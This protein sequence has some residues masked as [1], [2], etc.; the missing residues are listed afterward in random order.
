L[1]SRAHN[2]DPAHEAAGDQATTTATQAGLVRLRHAGNRLSGFD[3]RCGGAAA[4]SAFVVVAIMFAVNIEAR[5]QSAGGHFAFI[6]DL[7]TE[8]DNVFGGAGKSV[9]VAYGSRQELVSLIVHYGNDMVRTYID[10]SA[11]N[12]AIRP[13]DKRVFDLPLGMLKLK[14]SFLFDESGCGPR[15]HFGCWRGTGIFQ[16]Y[17]HSHTGKNIIL[18]NQNCVLWLFHEHISPLND[19]SVASLLFTDAT[20][21]NC[22]PSNNESRQSGSGRSSFVRMICNNNPESFEK[23]YIES[24]AAYMCGGIIS[25]SLLFFAWWFTGRC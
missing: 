13:Q 19:A 11:R 5:A 4:L 25:A 24:F 2:Y 7:K 1:T 10:I 22:E 20:Q 9:V 23:S 8:F 18:I 12:F 14:G 6:K 16:G 17:P 3:G 21:N 15:A